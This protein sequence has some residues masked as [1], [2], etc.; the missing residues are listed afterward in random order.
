MQ[1][2]DAELVLVGGTYAHWR[3][4]IEA[5]CALLEKKG[6][7]NKAYVD[8]VIEREYAFPTGLPTQPYGV[9]IPHAFAK[10]DVLDPCIGVSLLRTPVKFAQAGGIEATQVDVRLI[11]LLA[12]TS[13]DTH[14]QILST[15]S[16]MFTDQ[17]ALQQVVQAQSAQEFAELMQ[18]F[19]QQ[20][21]EV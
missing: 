11:F 1:Y 16:K 15:L 17:Q 2:F 9:A 10:E 6:K 13:A 18:H 12:I 7:V 3:D 19:M 20:R 8:C 21:Q 5:L 14:L 4:A